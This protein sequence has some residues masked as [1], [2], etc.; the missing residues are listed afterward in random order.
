MTHMTFFWVF[1]GRYFADVA[2]AL[3]HLH[4]FGIAAGSC[5]CFLWAGGC[6]S[7]PRFTTHTYTRES[8][9][10]ATPTYCFFLG[11]APFALTLY[12]ISGR[13]RRNVLSNS[14]GYRQ[15]RP[16][17]ACVWLVFSGDKWQG[18]R[19]EKVLGN[20]MHIRIYLIV[21]LTYLTIIYK[22]PVRLE[23]NGELKC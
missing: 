22:D 8:M 19:C 20:K 1:F 23:A 13:A 4:K 16:F 3:S 12:F 2:V 15:Q 9:N 17:G 10:G 6:I 21:R 7:F 5:K 18:K 11:L 14:R